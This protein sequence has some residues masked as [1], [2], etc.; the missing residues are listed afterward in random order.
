M[1]GA[2][3]ALAAALTFGGPAPVALA[4]GPA[5]PSPSV[6][7]PGPT[8]GLELDGRP[9]PTDPPSFISG[10]RTFVPI[11]FVAEALGADV[12]WLPERREVRIRPLPD[13]P[14]AAGEI[15]LTVGYP[16]ARVAG[17]EVPLDVAP[18]IVGDRTFV[19]LRFVA[20]TLGLEVGWRGADRV[21]ELA[22]RPAVL[23]L[24]SGGGD[25]VAVVIRGWQL[26][27]YEVREL[28]GPDRLVIDFPGTRLTPL[29]PR[30]VRLDAPDARRVRAGQF[31]E[32]TARVVVDLAG[33]RP[34][35]IEPIPGGL[36]VRLPPYVAGVEWE[37]VGDR[38]RL[39][40]RTTRPAEATVAVDPGGRRLTLNLAGVVPGP[41]LGPVIAPEGVAFTALAVEPS[42]APGIG[43][44]VRLDL[45]YY[46]GHELRSEDGGRTVVLELEVS[47]LHGRHIWVDPGHGGQEIGARGPA[48][49][50]EKD[51]NLAVALALRDLLVLAGADVHM[52]RDRDATVGLYDR[53]AM[54]NRSGTD[55]FV[56]VHSNAA[57]SPAAGGTETYYWRNH[58]QSRLLATAIH[59]RLAEATGLADRG[60]RTANFVVLRESRA[61]AA[62]VEV[63]FLS[64]PAEEALLNDPAFQWR[65]AEGIRRGLIDFFRAVRS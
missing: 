13:V 58:P 47:S 51:V 18:Q 33:R 4:E 45:P 15:V 53:P 60:V 61:P 2:A 23:G 65:A 6:P 12:R 44:A 5:P 64:N 11:R 59:R 27:R 21:V 55:A 35:V 17:R 37:T 41:G 29:A 43:T 52:T 56:S 46:L 31:T 14:E 24:V 7:S 25:D 40:V 62:L 34:V 28:A 3:L 20:E 48:G 63:A 42:G 54:A 22:R 19:P 38:T 39:T 26:D 9:V 50:L 32:D 1:A 8:V 16:A 49:T 10:D 57:A 30:E 36:A